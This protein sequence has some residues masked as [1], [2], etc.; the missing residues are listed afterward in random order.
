VRA[1]DEGGA[2]AQRVTDWCALCGAPP[3]DTGHHDALEA[4]YRVT[5]RIRAKMGNKPK[6]QGKIISYTKKA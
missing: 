2:G 6:L 4:L 1:T 3:S 5:A